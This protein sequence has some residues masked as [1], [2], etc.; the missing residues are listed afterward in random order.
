VVHSADFTY[1][2]LRGG[3]S[4]AP[5]MELVIGRSEA[6]RLGAAMVEGTPL[7]G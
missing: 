5:L 6:V 7:G 1:L 2:E 3:S 4:V